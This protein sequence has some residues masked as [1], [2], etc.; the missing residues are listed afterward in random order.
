VSAGD[1]ALVWSDALASYHFRHEH[2]LNPRRL[3]LSVSLM[4][5]LGLLAD[6]AIVAPRAATEAELLTVHTQEYID[7][8]RRLSLPDADP[9]AGLPYGLGTEDTPVV[10]GMHEAASIIAGATLVAAEEIMSGRRRRAFSIAGGLHHARRAAAAGFCVYSDVGVAIKWMQHAHN[11]R[12][13]YIDFDAHHGDGVQEI[14]Y[15]D[16]TVLT[17]SFHESGSSLFPGTGF[18]DEMG[19]GRGLGYAVNVPLEAHTEDA[20]WLAAFRAIV[21]PLADAFK[22]DI[23]VVEC[24]ADGH[25]LDPLTHLRATTGLFEQLT[26]IVCDVADI[27][28]NGRVLAVGGGGYAA[29]TVVPRAWTLVWATLNGVT[30]QDRIP[31]KW[32]RAVRM[33]SG[34]EIPSILRDAPDAFPPSVRRAHVEATNERTVKSILSKALPL[35]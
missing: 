35:P 5:A 11:A 24:G 31:V 13:M 15:D 6:A 12:V 7:L 30:A 33:E 28:S 26:K 10:E 9:L 25:V 1:T 8:V 21:P 17:V 27:H 14:F 22:P 2:P 4:R 3:A 20:S 32:L 19:V 16:P 18:V 34:R 23:I 29:F